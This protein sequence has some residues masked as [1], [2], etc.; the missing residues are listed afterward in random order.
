MAV[1]MSTELSGAGWKVSV[2]PSLTW[3]GTYVEMRK[4]LRVVENIT[5]HFEQVTH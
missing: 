5:K 2:G 1:A 3:F 4:W